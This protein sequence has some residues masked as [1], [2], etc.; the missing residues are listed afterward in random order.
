MSKRSLINQLAQPQELFPELSVAE[1]EANR[2]T[3]EI[4]DQILSRRKELGKTQTQLANMV[5]VKQPMVCQWERGDCNFTIETLTDI[6]SHLDLRIE[7]SFLPLNLTSC[8]PNF[9]TE[10]KP[11]PLDLSPV[12]AA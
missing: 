5:G 6:F 10:S 12:E 4:A 9:Y 7:L 3:V 11:I 8:F 2:L 1:R